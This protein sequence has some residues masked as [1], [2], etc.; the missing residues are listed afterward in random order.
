M[1]WKFCSEYKLLEMHFFSLFPGK[2]GQFLRRKYIPKRIGSC[3]KNLIMAHNV[4][5]SS[6]ENLFLGDFVGVGIGA[7]FTAGGGIYIGNHVGI[8]PDVKIW[9]SNHIFK[10]PFTPWRCQGSELKSVNIGNDVWIAAGAIIKPGVRIGDGAIIGSGVVLSKSVPS[11][12]IVSGNP[13]RIVGW[14][15]HPDKNIVSVHGVVK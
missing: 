12:A 6:P 2:S 5:I 7:Y 9:S 15:L 14:R 13:G 10:D 3:G 8:G 1:Y 4:K 11:Y